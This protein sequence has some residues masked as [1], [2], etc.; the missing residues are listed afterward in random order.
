MKYWEQF[1]SYKERGEWVELQ[2]M[3][4]A[5]RR[6]FAVCKP[7]GETHY[8]DIGIEHGPNFLRV[9]I[10]STVTGGMPDTGATSSPITR[11]VESTAWRSSICLRRT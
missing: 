11:Q 7:W 3:A 9:Q 2:F 10:K 4:Q 1:R 6:Q 8:Y 5:A